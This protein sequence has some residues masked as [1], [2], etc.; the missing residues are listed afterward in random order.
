VL[1]RSDSASATRGPMLT[2]GRALHVLVPVGRS[3]KSAAEPCKRRWDGSL[4]QTPFPLHPSLCDEGMAIGA[5]RSLMMAA[6]QSLE[7][8]NHAPDLDSGKEREGWEQI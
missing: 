2:G 1:T 5:G 8:T 7:L 4:Q 3:T 6:R